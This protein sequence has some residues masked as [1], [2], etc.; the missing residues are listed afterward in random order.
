MRAFGE[1]RD[2]GHCATASVDFSLKIAGRPELPVLTVRST[3]RCNTLTFER[4]V[5][6]DG[7]TTRTSLLYR[8]REY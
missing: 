1:V 5:E 4:E 7:T 3:D 6:C 2:P 8:G